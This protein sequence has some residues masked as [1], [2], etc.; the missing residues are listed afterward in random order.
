[1]AGFV[2]WYLKRSD[3]VYFVLIWIA[4]I[5]FDRTLGYGLKYDSGFKFTHLGRIGR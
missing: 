1:M 4:H 5:G 3:L 2:L